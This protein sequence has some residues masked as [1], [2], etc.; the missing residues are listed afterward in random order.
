MD[1]NT[2]Y[3]NITT[4]Y[5]TAPTCDSTPK[6]R[7]VSNHEWHDSGNSYYVSGAVIQN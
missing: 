5:A 1:Y 7:T 4:G 2:T 6:Y 3:K